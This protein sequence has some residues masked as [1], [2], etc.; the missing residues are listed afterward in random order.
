MN[1]KYWKAF[2]GEVKEA[3]PLNAPPARGRSVLIRIY[4]DAEHGGNMVTRRSRTRYVQFVNNT[5]VNW[6][7]RKQGSI[8]TSTFGSE[9]VPL[10]TA[11]EANRGLRYKLRMIGVPIDGPS[12]V[13]CDDQSV[14]ANS[15]RQESLLKK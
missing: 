5:V 14:I 15:S 2:F 6:F 10:K 4:I 3:L 12:Y 1:D 11:K 9:F 8:E 7:Y 13:F